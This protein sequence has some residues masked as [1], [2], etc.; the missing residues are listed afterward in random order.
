MTERLDL[1]TLRVVIAVADSGSISAGSDRLQLAVAAASARISSM[2]ASLGIRIFERS[3]RGVA[4]TPAGRML[5]QRGRELLDGADQLATDLRDWSLGLAGHVRMLVNA[6]ALLEVLPPRLEAFMRSHPRI[7]VDVEE[8][9]SPEILGAL[10]EGRADVGVVDVAIQSRD[11]AFTPFF[12]D[13]L[14]LVVP[15][16]HPLA[17][18]RELRLPQ[19]LAENFIVLAG[20]NAVATRLFNAAAAIGEPIQVRMQMRS[21][22]AASRM[23]AAGLGVAVLPMEA[24][25]PQLAH[26]P[27]KAV[28]L[29]EDWAQ[30]T[31]YLA[32]RTAVEAPA[33]ARTLVEAL[34]SG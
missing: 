16:Q 23:V 29:A 12:R 6:S 32:L 28:P 15:A 7:H 19:I 22:D 31:H 9:I 20:A 34:R 18:E 14:A 10:L 3:P 11:L 30:R 8:R 25:A 17:G 21:F 1:L 24:I 33:A 13:Q 2:E 27:V 5:V 4:L 26:L